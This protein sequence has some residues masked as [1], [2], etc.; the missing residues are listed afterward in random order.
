MEHARLKGKRITQKAR[1]AGDADLGLP[2]GADRDKYYAFMK[3][4]KDRR[5]LTGQIQNPVKFTSYELLL[6]PWIKTLWQ[7]LARY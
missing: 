1:I 3:I 7:A 2:A 4:V 6:L 5:K